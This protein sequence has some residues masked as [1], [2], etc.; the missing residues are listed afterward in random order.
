MESGELGGSAVEEFLVDGEVGVRVLTGLGVVL[1]ALPLLRH[2][3]AEALLVDGQAGFGGHLQGQVDRETVRVVERERLVA[4]DRRLAGRLHRLGGA[5]EQL[6]AGR[7]GLEERGLLADRDRLDAAEVGV[8]DGVRRRHR[9]A[10]DGDELTHAGLVGAEQLRGPDDAPQQAAQD[11]AAPV[12]AGVHAVGDEHR[13]G[14]RVVGDD[15][16]AHVVVVDGAVLAA[17]QFL[18]LRDD[19]A[20]EV[21]LVHVVDALE[22]ERDALD[23]HAGVDVLLRQR[24]EDLEVVLADAERRARSA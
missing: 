22:Q 3:R 16:E 9:V 1:R 11:V 10:D 4:A 24:A 17:G 5:F 6:R 7:Q 2:Q 14:A 8:E 18:G 13:G 19:R 21:G 12:V 15:P 20:H 23:A